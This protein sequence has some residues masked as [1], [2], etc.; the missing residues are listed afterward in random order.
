MIM[1]A[2]TSPIFSSVGRKFIMAVTGLGWVL[3]VIAHLFGNLTLLMG[4]EAFN[5]YAHFLESLMHGLFIYFAEAGLIL[6]LVAHAISGVWVYI[7][8]LRAR[9]SRYAV[10]A[11]AGGV[12]RKTLSSRAMILTGPLL[13][14]FIVLHVLHFKYGPE[15][16]TTVHGVVM[17]DLYRLVV[18]EFH[19]PLI[20]ALYVL[21]MIL[22]GSHLRHGVWSA[23]QSLGAT[24]PSVIPALCRLSLAVGIVLAFGFIYIPLHVMLFIKTTGPAVAAMTGGLP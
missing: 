13:L 18:A 2:T 15:Y 23:I 7:N 4:P 17:R 24:R 21:V 3:F 14:V 5:G 8:K 19:K 10:T 16:T 12:S 1:S 22:L 11:D 9:G 6:F 20:T